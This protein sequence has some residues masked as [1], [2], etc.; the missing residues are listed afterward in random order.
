M[1]SLLLEELIID[2]DSQNR[3]KGINLMT[4][5]KSKG[6]E[7]KVVVIISLNDG[8]IPSKANTVDQYDEERRICYVSMTRAKERLLLTSARQHFIN[9][10]RKVLRP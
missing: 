5:H 2:D 3:T 4:I 7:F 6:L 8:I 1:S 9:G 10:K